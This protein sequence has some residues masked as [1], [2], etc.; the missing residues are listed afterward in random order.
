MSDLADRLR[1]IAKSK[2]LPH[3]LALPRLAPSAGR[4][5]MVLVGSAATGLCQDGSDID[6]AV[7]CDSMTYEAIASG[8]TWAAG[9]PAEDEIGGVQLHYYGV[10]FDAI[11][12]KL[13][14]LD[15]LALYVYG[16]A[17]VLWDPEGRYEEQFHWLSEQ[18][19]DI[20]R[21]RIEGKLDM[22]SR[23]TR[24]LVSLLAEG[25]ILTVARVCLE[26]ITRC[27]K[28]AALLDGI[29]FDPR[30][31]LFVSALTGDTGRR[32]EPDL[33]RLLACVGDLAN[34]RKSGDFAAFA[35]P[36]ILRSVVDILSD[37]GGK[38]GFQVGLD[39]PD[40]RQA[41]E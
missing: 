26:L 41:Y 17:V 6:I 31:R 1:S 30:K 5:S 40:R 12:A 8:T 14:D 27:L 39:A 10:E 28:L 4:L 19:E 20:R 15:D 7:V 23:R 29:P 37:E 24:A 21:K 35:F 2:C 16:N 38:Q 22:L 13:R 33:R 34:L 32:V 36:P 9:K 3:L 11:Q 25:D 18:A